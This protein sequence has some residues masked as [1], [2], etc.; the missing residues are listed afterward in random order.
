MSNF[1]MVIPKPYSILFLSRPYSIL[2]SEFP[3]HFPLPI[4]HYRSPFGEPIKGHPGLAL[5]E[6]LWKLLNRLDKVGEHIKLLFLVF[7]L[8][9]VCVFS[10]AFQ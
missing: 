7:A 1:E 5:H 4:I 2:R 10:S 8:P 9:L 6:K 3:T